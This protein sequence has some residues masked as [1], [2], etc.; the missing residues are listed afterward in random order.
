[1]FLIHERKFTETHQVLFQEVV[2]CIPSI[3]STSSCLVID[4]EK[5]IIKAA[6]IEVSNL[7]QL[8]CWNHIYRDIRFW[9]RKRGAPSTDITIYIDNISNLFHSA[10]ED[11]Y[12]ERLDHY[13]K[14]W[15]PVFEEYFKKKIHPIVPH[16]VGRWLLE[17]YQL[18]NPYCGVTNNQAEG[19]NRVMK[20]FQ[21]WKEAPLDSFVLALYQLQ[22]FYYNEIQR[23]LAG[24]YTY[25]HELGKFAHICGYNCKAHVYICTICVSV[26]TK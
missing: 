9:L 24:T 5:A 22:A 12:N 13:S 8:Q 6:E 17:S 15:D 11:E 25:V 10:S 21:Q 2:R 4:R 1:M 20:D 16:K 18:Y 23:G 26:S 3:K 19:F 14:A 7:Q